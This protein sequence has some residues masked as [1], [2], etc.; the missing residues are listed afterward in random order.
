M[1]DEEKKFTQEDVDKIVQERLARE[2]AKYADY[3]QIK[4]ELE[5]TRA[6]HA[7][8]RA[9]NVTLKAE[10]AER[11][12]KAKDSEL[13]AQKAEIAKKAGLPEALSSRIEGAT[14]EELEADALR[15]AE[16]LGPGP[17]VGT[18][19]NPPTGAKRPLT[20]ADIKKMS[21]DEIVSNW[22][23]IKTQLKDGSLSRV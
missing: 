10:I 12:G 22:D 8:L 1:A 11:D 21:P 6:S 14:P 5:A 2:R 23:Q 3:D 13:K 4:A 20:R 7:E 17:S 18:G 16:S 19:T 9:E 15:L